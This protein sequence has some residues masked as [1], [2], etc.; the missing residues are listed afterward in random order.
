M[1]PALASET[2]VAVRRV[3]ARR[4]G[5]PADA[6]GADETVRVSRPDLTATVVVRLGATTVVATPDQAL[7]DL[8]QLSSEQLMD[9]RSLLSALESHGPTL[10]GEASL[11]CADPG[12][13]S[14]AV[15]GAVRD[16]VE[17]DLEAVLSACSN[18]ERDES[19][20]A[21][22]STRLVA[23]DG[24]GQPAALAG[25]EVWDDT[26]AQMGLA[27]PPG[28]RGQGFGRQVAIDL[29]PRSRGV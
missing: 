11:A 1:T 24:S 21:H 20:L 22:M 19:G 28:S 27:V 14:P 4:L 7:S 8:R 12:T 17:A 3:W 26:L 15:D 16:A 5:V 6:F 10:L 9:A 29:A 18:D 13:M 2:E 23:S 25:Y